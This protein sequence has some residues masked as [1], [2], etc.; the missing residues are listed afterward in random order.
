M[1]TDLW[2]QQTVVTSSLITLG[3]AIG[4]GMLFCFFFLS[5]AEKVPELRQAT[6]RV[7]SRDPTHLCM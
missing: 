7:W 4:S 5:L 2:K 3:G 6:E 1:A